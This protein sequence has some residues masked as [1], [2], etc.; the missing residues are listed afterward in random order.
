MS[1][2]HAWMNEFSLLE[3]KRLHGAL[4]EADEQRWWEL[5]GALGLD[6][7]FAQTGYYAQDGHWYPY[8]HSEAEAVSAA[9]EAALPP[10]DDPL[11]HRYAA[12]PVDDVPMLED[13]AIEEVA[14]LPDIAKL[15]LELAP[16]LQPEP[17]PVIDLFAASAIERAEEVLDLS[18]DQAIDSH[19]PAVVD[20]TLPAEMRMTGEHKVVLHTLEGQVKRGILRDADLGSAL[21][22]LEPQEGSPEQLETEELKAIFFM[23]PPGGSPPPA[24]G[25]RVH[26]TLRDGRELTGF[27]EDYQTDAPGFFLVPS[28]AR[29][30]TGRVFIYRRAVQA[31]SPD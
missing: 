31:L 24:H 11:A 20:A 2:A 9:L 7:A 22:P 16:P 18:L 4:T 25:T 21:L 12:P 30:N 26:V 14:E 10:D 6:P 15:E 19:L 5:V 29:G 1:D 27:S 8:P 13:D 23:L 3:G 17:A 28:D